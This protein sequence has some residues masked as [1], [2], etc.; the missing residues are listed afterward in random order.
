MK[1]QTASNINSMLIN[2]IKKIYIPL[3]FSDIQHNFK[4][5]V[6]ELT[7][8]QLCAELGRTIKIVKEMT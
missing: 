2:I 5:T 8:T 4:P 6:E 7:M 3:S 1:I